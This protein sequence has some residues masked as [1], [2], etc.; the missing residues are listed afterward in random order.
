[1][2]QIRAPIWNGG[3][4]WAGIADYRINPASLYTEF[5]I[6]YRNKEGHRTFP[7]PYRVTTAEL[8]QCHSRKVGHGVTVLEIPLSRCVEVC[9]A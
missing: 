3:K 6:I 1:M 9:H 2:I 5:E 4:P 7:N 8:I